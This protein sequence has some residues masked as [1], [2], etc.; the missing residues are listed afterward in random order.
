LI[1]VIS[2]PSLLNGMISNRALCK[3][4]ELMFSEEQFL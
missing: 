3:L 2:A 1:P 4:A